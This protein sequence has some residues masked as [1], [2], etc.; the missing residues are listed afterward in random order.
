MSSLAVDF[1][2]WYKITWI[3]S[4]GLLFLRDDIIKIMGTLNL[5]FHEDRLKGILHLLT[6]VVFLPITLPFTL[7]NILNRC[8]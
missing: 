7:A 1:V 5:T 4:F 2:F 3:I 6:V 8:L